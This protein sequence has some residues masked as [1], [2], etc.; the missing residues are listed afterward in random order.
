MDQSC[1]PLDRRRVVPSLGVPHDSKPVE[2][3][4]SDAD[5]E[6]LA[7]DYGIIFGSCEQSELGST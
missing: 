2:P 1:P 7:H 4:H 3:W 5:R 6:V